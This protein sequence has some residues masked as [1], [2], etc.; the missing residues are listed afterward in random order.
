MAKAFEL[1]TMN[2]SRLTAR[3]AGIESTAN[4]TSLGLDDDQHGQQRRGQQLAAVPHEQ[5]L[6]VVLGGRRYDAPHQAEDRVLL[7]VDLLLALAHEAERRDQQER[8]EHEEQP[9]ELLEQRHAGEDEDEPQHERAEDA[10]EQRPE[11]ELPGTAK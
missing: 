11:L 8:P 9:L 6:A 4:T 1:K 5:V 10:P 2:C 3:M 7:G